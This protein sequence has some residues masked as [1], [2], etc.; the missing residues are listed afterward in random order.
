MKVAEHGMACKLAL[1]SREKLSNTTATIVLEWY[2]MAANSVTRVLLAL[3]F[4][5]M[6]ATMAA[7]KAKT[8][9][10]CSKESKEYEY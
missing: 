7:L 2:F 5:A 10:K 8:S 1:Q 9:E 4:H 3:C 6:L